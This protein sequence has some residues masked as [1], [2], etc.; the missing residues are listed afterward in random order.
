MAKRRS[1]QEALLAWH[2]AEERYGTAVR[3]FLPGG[4]DSLPAMTKDVAVTLARA[5]VK[6]DNL[7]EEYV[8]ICL[9]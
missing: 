7:M 1:Q 5:R 9:D 6:A 8:R 3:P 4:A 2:Q